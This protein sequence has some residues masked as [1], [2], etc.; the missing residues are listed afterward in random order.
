VARVRVDHRTSSLLNRVTPNP[1]KEV[2]PEAGQRRQPA[3]VP[4]HTEGRS[5]ADINFPTICAR[6]CRREGRTASMQD[7][8]LGRERLLHPSFYDLEFLEL[9]T[10]VKGS[11]GS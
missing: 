9:G 11:D 6:R 2:G 1:K 3:G 4:W 8:P 10:L 7:R 5:S